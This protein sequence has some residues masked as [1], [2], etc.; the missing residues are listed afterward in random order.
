SWGI[1]GVGTT[2]ILLVNEQP[3]PR[4]RPGRPARCQN[5]G[6]VMMDRTR[7]RPR[8]ALRSRCG[9][10]PGNVAASSARRSMTES[11]N[12]SAPRPL[13]MT[14]HSSPAWLSGPGA[15]AW[16]ASMIT[17]M[18]SSW[19]CVDGLSN[20]K[21][22]PDDGRPI[23]TRSP[24]RTTLTASAST[25]RNRRKTGTSSAVA[26][27]R[28][29]ATDGW[30]APDSIWLI[31]AALTP[32]LRASEAIVRCRCSRWARTVP[33]SSAESRRSL[34]AAPAPTP[35]LVINSLLAY[36]HAKQQHDDEHAHELGVV[37][38]RAGAGVKP[39][40][41]QV[42]HDPVRVVDQH[43]VGAAVVGAEDRGIGVASHEF[44]AALVVGAV[45]QHVLG[46][47]DAGYAFHVDRDKN[48]HG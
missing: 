6:G 41:Q 46:V 10:G 30:T 40:E 25:G 14:R 48:L 26:S 29:V 12:S 18:T 16:P 2:K 35:C 42:A 44:P 38:D 36:L 28:S 9:I 37:L 47:G 24:R 32:T 45:G 11:P 8:P 13:R 4:R 1:L 27:L 7:S 43:L 20:S 23:E 34:S 17:S 39:L 31:A 19:P 15:D 21:R 3:V 22:A 5:D 33:P